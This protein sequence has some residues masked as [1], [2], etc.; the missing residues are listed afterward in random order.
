MKKFG[1]GLIPHTG[2]GKIIALAMIFVFAMTALPVLKI[3]ANSTKMWGPLPMTLSWSYLWYGGMMLC[4][5]FIYGL[6]FKPWASGIV[7]FLAKNDDKPEIWSELLT[8]E[9]E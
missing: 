7:E 1:T 8:R 3:F 5:W 9:K 4:G 6:L 2:K